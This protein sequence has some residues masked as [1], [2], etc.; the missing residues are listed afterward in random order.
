MSGVPAVVVG[1]VILASTSHRVGS[2]PTRLQ[3]HAVYDTVVFLLESVGHSVIAATNAEAGVALARDQQPALIL[4]DI[5]LPGMDGLQATAL[6]K[7]DAMT[8]KI[9][10][11]V[12]SVVDRPDVPD[13][14]DAHVSKPVQHDPLLRVLGEH[15]TAP[16]VQ[17]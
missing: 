2:A 15:A 1:S 8:S 7:G 17:R 12:M 3:I 16:Q 11:I 6:L 5:Q 4:M 10:V 9:P 13:G 14:A